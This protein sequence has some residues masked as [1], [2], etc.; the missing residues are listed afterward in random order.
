MGKQ[1]AVHVYAGVRLSLRKE[2]NSDSCFSMDGPGVNQSARCQRT[3]TACSYF[4]Q[5]PRLVAFTETE[6]RTVA[7]GARGGRRGKCFADAK[8]QSGMKKKF[9]GQ[10]AGM[11]A[12]VTWPCL[13]LLNCS[14]KNS[15]NVKFH[16]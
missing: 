6:S 8:L 5:A 16:V 14:L 10:T 9:W 4:Y 1:N 7:A 12:C 13:T 2:G 3:N 15:Q 11:A